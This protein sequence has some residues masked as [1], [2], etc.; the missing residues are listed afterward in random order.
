MK[1]SPV[2]SDRFSIS[3]HEPSEVAY[4]CNSALHFPSL[5]KSA[6][7]SAILD[8]GFFLFFRWGTIRSIPRCLNCLRSGSLSYALWATKRSGRFLGL[9]GPFLGTL[10][11]SSVC[12][13]SFTSAGDAEARELPKGIPEPSATT[14]HFVPLP[15][16]VLPTQGPPFFAGAKL[17]SIKAS[18][19]PKAPLAS[20]S[21]KNVRPDIKP[22][23]QF[24]PQ[25]Q[26]PPESRWTRVSA[27]KIFP[28]GCG[29]EYP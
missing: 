24:F 14:I 8:F 6:E 21:A 25:L 26:T 12:P 11:C 23:R 10:I 22:D 28:S 20:S 16:L 19:Q 4:P 15:F 27:G 5:S 9:P 29:P 18:C 7:L 3:D 17:P 13:T 2:N 1:E